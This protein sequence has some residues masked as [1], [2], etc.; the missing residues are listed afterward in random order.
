MIIKV[1]LAV[2][3]STAITLILFWIADHFPDF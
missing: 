1:I 2:V 3:L